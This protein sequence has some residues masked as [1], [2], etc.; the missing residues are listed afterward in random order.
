MNSLWIILF[1]IAAYIVAY[2]F[3]GTFIEKKIFRANP[4]NPVPSEELR[5]DIDYIPTNKEVLFGHHFASIAGA[6][7][8]IGPVIACM[9]FGW[10]PSL[11]WVVLGAIF[12][13]GIHDFGSL[14]ISVR[15][16]G[17]TIGD[18][19]AKTISHK[20]KIIL[21]IFTWLALILVIA[22]FAY[23]GA[24]TFVTQPEIVLPSFGIIPVAIIVGLA[25]YRFKWSTGLVTVAGAWCT[26]GYQTLRVVLA[27]PVLALKHE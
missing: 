18:I 26:V 8:I 5:D 4:D 23:L 13:G 19:A 15:E 24:K 16:E 14:M 11:L 1:T 12:L 3:Y 6:G 7:P 25:M 22:V 10:L 21:L 9:L 20:A 17:G 2:K 27:D